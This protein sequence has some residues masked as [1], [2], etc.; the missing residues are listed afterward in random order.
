MEGTIIGVA[1]LSNADANEALFHKHVH[2]VDEAR[3][4]AAR[5]TPMHA[6][7][8][9][10]AQGADM[11]LAACR[12]WLK[13]CKDTPAERRDALLKKYLGSQAD[14]EEG[15]TL[16]CIHNSLILSKGLL[17]IS[18]MPKGE[19]EGVLAF[20]VPSSQCTM[21]LNGIHWDA[22]YQG[23]QRTLNL[24]Q[25][26]FWWPI[27]VEDCNAL[28]RGCPRCHAFKGAIPN[29]P[30]CPIRAHTPLELVHVDFSSVESTMELN[31]P[32]SIK[33]MLVII[34]H[35]TCYALAVVMKDHMAKTVANV[36]YERFIVVFSMP[37]KPLSDYGANFTLALIEEVCAAFG[38]QC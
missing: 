27:M 7:N 32:P 29:D 8:W 15:C 21:A 34:D 30:L 3:V 9:E 37:A 24:V 22:G 5:L 17:Y 31:K 19:L 12:N 28:L 18:T 36:I 1:D 2:L 16:F 4:Q 11:V 26:H 13:A 23:Q 6:V 33:N 10:D 25:E 38:I 20:L 14:T 35:F